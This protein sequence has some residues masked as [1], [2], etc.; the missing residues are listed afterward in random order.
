MQI[1]MF[2]R[3]P[4][5][6]VFHEGVFE[7][8]FVDFD[9]EAV[10]VEDVE[11]FAAVLAGR[12]FVKLHSDFVDAGESLV[13]EIA[14]DFVFAPFAIAFQIIDAVD[15]VFVEDVAE[16][17]HFGALDDG[18]GLIFAVEQFDEHA[19]P[20]F[21]LPGGVVVDDVEARIGD[22]FER[23]AIEPGGGLNGDDVGDT[24]AIDVQSQHVDGAEW[25]RWQ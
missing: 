18:G 2:S 1:S 20:E 16:R 25:V 24:C 5:H 15:V 11:Q 7:P 4:K 6:P 12:V 13:V 3:G 8:R 10:A 23:A 21:G 19:R 17:F 22:D 14:E 9:G